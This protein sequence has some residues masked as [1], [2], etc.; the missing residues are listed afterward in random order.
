MK[1]IVLTQSVLVAFQEMEAALELAF[2]KRVLL[3]DCCLTP[4]NIEYNSYVPDKHYER[5][6]EVSARFNC[7]GEDE[8]HVVV[9][10]LWV[11]S[12]GD[13]HPVSRVEYDANNIFYIDGD[14]Y[15]SRWQAPRS[16]KIRRVGDEG[17]WL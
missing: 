1:P 13:I 16:L 3:K 17:D 5:K 14:K 6:I 8:L 7:V 10:G 2:G 12:H 9:G 4:S 11:H 15:E